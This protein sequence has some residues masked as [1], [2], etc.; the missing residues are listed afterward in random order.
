[1]CQAFTWDEQQKKGYFK[2]QPVNDKYNLGN[3]RTDFTMCNTPNVTTWILNAGTTGQL[4]VY[5]S[6]IRFIH[7]VK[8]ASRHIPLHATIHKGFA[9]Q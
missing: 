9:Q 7:C 2:G 5:M 4:D 6:A 8:Q 1:M 3:L